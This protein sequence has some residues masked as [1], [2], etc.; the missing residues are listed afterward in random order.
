MI[1]IGELIRERLCEIERT[2]T[3]LAKKINCDRTNIHK[4]FQRASIDTELLARISKALDYNFFIDL[5]K[6]KSSKRKQQ[7]SCKYMENEFPRAIIF[8]QKGFELM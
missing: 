3:W 4:I 7:W 2:P 1:H 6:N 5:S 8:T